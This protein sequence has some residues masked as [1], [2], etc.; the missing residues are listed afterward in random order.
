MAFLFASSRSGVC[1]QIGDN[2]RRRVRVV[3]PAF[4]RVSAIG[5]RLQMPSAS[6]QSP[7]A[8]GVNMLAELSQPSAPLR[9]IVRTSRLRRDSAAS[10][11]ILLALANWVLVCA[12]AGCD[13]P[14]TATAAV[15]LTNGDAS[16]VSVTTSCGPDQV[17]TRE[18]CIEQPVIKVNS[19]GYLPERNKFATLPGDIT[20]ATFTVRNA[21]THEVAYIGALPT[22]VFDQADTGEL[23]KIADFSSLQDRGTYTLEVLGYPPSPPFDIRDSVNNDL[24][25]LSL[26]GFYGQRCGQQVTV[27]SAGDTFEHDTCHTKDATFDEALVQGMTGNKDATGGWHDAG[28]YGKYTVNGA[29]S[30]VF[31]TK[32]WEDFGAALTAADHMT[33]NAHML[34]AILDEAKY[35]LDWLLKMQ[36]LDGGVLHLVCPKT[37]P[38]LSVRPEK[39]RATRY[40]LGVSSSATA[41]FTAATAAA[42][43]VFQSMDEEYAQQLLAAARR[44]QSWLD[45]HDSDEPLHNSPLAGGP[46]APSDVEARVWANVELWRSTGQGDRAAIEGAVAKLPVRT[47]W[48]WA[49]PGN[50]AVFS[51]AAAQSNER[52]PA[53]LTS[54]NAAIVDAANTL[55]R[56]ATAHAYGRAL[57]TAD[58]NWGSNGSVARSAMNLWAA[59]RIMSDPHYLDTITQQLDYLLG[60]NPFGRSFVTG[61]GFAP[62]LRPHH[63]PSSGDQVP[64]PWPGLLVGGPYKNPQDA[65]ASAELPP[66][67]S[68]FDVADDFYVNEVAINWNAALL[69]AA[70][71]FVK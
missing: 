70:A 65:L 61:V 10:S 66:G 71:G 39:D 42:A 13:P 30:V 23:L 33:G 31:L 20:A 9:P 41:Y 51:Y 54:V 57:A 49:N 67:K 35:E 22:T 68:W 25:R 6:S 47:S 37:Y 16:T 69:Y 64:A 60:R 19:L 14:A 18:G 50:L 1:L 40:F 53:V 43:R 15:E 8:C 12:A 29:F 24:V 11:S 63:R 55:A 3:P 28:D 7:S 45:S 34:P 59:Y 58:Y 2:E 5:S 26:M 4:K 52:D 21:L 32:A 46:Y 38:S 27:T 44:G 56:Q 62:P 17:K 36:Q 48:D